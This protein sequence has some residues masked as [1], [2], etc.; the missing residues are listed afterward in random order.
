[1]QD[2]DDSPAFAPGRLTVEMQAELDRLSTFPGEVVDCSRPPDDAAR[3]LD[4]ANNAVWNVD[5]PEVAKVRHFRIDPD[6]SLGAVACE[7]VA[8]EPADAGDG[9]IFYIHGGGW[10]FMNLAT[11]ERFMRVLANEAGKTVVGV[12]YRLA[13][14][15]PYPAA[16]T[17][18]VSAFRTVL[19]SRDTLG[20]P[21]GPVVIAGDSAGGN[22]AVATMLYEIDAG[23]ELPV[24]AL[25]LYGVLGA[26]FETPSYKK[27]SEGYVLTE[28]SMR[29]MWNWYAPDEATRQDPLANPIAATDAQLCALPPLFLLVAEL[30]PLAS[31]THNFKKRLDAV[32]RKDAL[33]VERGV[34]HG[35]L[36]MTATL[37]AARRVTGQAAQAAVR[38]IS[39]AKRPYRP[40]VPPPMSVSA[41]ARVS[42]SAPLPERQTYPDVH[43]DHGWTQ[44]VSEVNASHAPLWNMLPKDPSIV[45]HRQKIKGVSVCA[46]NVPNCLGG[47]RRVYLDI[48]G[49]AL[50]YFGGDLV[51]NWSRSIATRTQSSVISIDYRMPPKYPFPAALDDCVKVYRALVES[52]GAENIIVGGSSAGGNLA[53]ALVLRARDD[54]IALPAGLV[55]L[56]PEVDLTESGDTFRTLFGLDR[57]HSLMPIN[58]LYAAGAPLDDPYVSPLFADFS[59]GFP[60]T[61][62][63]SGTR[64]M[65]LSNTVR[66]HRALRKAN[67]PAELHVW[68][69]MQHGGFVGAPED[70]EV[71]DELQKFIRSTWP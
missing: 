3:R 34:I 49:G 5:L 69:A 20:L 47:E 22:L 42:L 2:P 25:I 61:F 31:D 17:D 66:M 68:E 63:Q 41:E 7:A 51:E 29:Q 4:E 36:Q 30:D 27:Y 24:G 14:E 71:D 54:G 62:L 43:D 67:I 39:E 50:V 35:F 64:D 44:H 40:S 21:G 9:I 38:F 52:H 23:R 58:E 65:F 13:P 55:L 6:E 28:F 70:H 11:H 15:H 56:S 33:W 12:H 10:A 53:A 19:S 8:Y 32:G 16:L 46:A 45:P 18:V 59:R 1:M 37:E 60:R 57:L 26:D 48:H